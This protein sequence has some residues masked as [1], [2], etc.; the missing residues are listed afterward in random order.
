[1]NQH[2]HW[3]RC[4]CQ[5]STH[6]SI[7]NGAEWRSASG[8]GGDTSAMQEH[9]GTEHN[10]NKQHVLRRDGEGDQARTVIVR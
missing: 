1:M 7:E 5:H 2:E 3:D 4:I 6:C 8:G 10:N 9:C